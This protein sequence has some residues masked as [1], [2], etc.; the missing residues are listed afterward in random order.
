MNLE[1][2]AYVD[3]RSRA[4]IALPAIRSAQMA[5]ATPTPP[6]PEIPVPADTPDPATPPTEVPAQ[7]IAPDTQPE[8]VAQTAAARAA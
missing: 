2:L 3:M 7:P 8:H 4:H 6:V 1:T 5:D